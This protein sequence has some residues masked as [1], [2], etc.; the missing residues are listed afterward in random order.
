M[1]QTVSAFLFPWEEEG[2]VENTNN[3]EEDEGVSEIRTPVS[4]PTRQPPSMEAT[5]A[6]RFNENLQNSS[7]AR[8]LFDL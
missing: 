1:T 2:S 4:K 8:Q 5:P 6:V 3:I 7:A